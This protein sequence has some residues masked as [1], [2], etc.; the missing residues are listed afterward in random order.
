M[1]HPVYVIN[2]FYTATASG[3]SSVLIHTGAT[4]IAGLDIVGPVWEGWTMTDDLRTGVI[5]LVINVVDQ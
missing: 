3:K 5:W 2:L 4:V 1:C